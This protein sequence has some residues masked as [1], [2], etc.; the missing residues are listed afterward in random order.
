MSEVVSPIAPAS[1]GRGPCGWSIVVHGGAG[2]VPEARR[3]LHVAGCEAA[4][5]AGAEVLAAGGSAVDAVERAVLVLEADPLF[6]AGHGACLNAEGAIELDATI[7]EGTG[8]M[9]GGVAALPPFLHPIAIARRV[10][11]ASSHVL[12]AGEAA[13]R[14]AETAGF[15]RA[16]PAELVTERARARLEAVRR[17]GE[18]VLEA[19]DDAERPGGTVGAVAKDARG[20]VAAA[21]STGGMINKLPGRVGDSALVGAG[22]Y[23]DDEAGACSTT[24]HGEA[25]IRVTFARSAI[26]ALRSGALP[27]PED[28]LGRLLTAMRA[29]V[30]GTGG[31][32]LVQRDGALGLARTTPTMSWAA[33][34][35]A[36]NASGA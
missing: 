16:G 22:T 32:I 6:N 26:E 23:A 19:G 12:L 17:G 31:A 34:T 4:A 10:M 15:V 33:C 29:R 1:W 9:A 24:G 27:L 13:A 36:G 11:E 7:M 3:A 35:D 8:L 5:R 21:T 30:G 2:F 28:A 14:F 25:M 18:V 20:R